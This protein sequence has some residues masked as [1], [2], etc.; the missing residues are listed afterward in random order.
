MEQLGITEKIIEILSGLLTPLLA[1]IATLILYWQFRLEKSRWR[2][3]LYDKRYPVF[4]AT[5][6]YLSFIAK[7]D[8]VTQ[9]ELLKFLRN[10]KDM[11]FLF[12]NDL[13]EYLRK[14][15]KKGV[16]VRY[17]RKKLEHEPVGEKRTKL[18]DEQSDLVEWFTKQFE[19]SKALFGKYLR[20]EKK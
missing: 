14:L 18:V 4:L 1:I 13:K 6:Q 19:V 17:L 3:D 7:E 9:E 8:T 11:D 15:Y 2:L 10:S 16:R 5:M 20:I 12:A